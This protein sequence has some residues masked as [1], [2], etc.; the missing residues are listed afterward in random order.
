MGPRVAPGLQIV[1]LGDLPVTEFRSLVFVSA[2]VG[3]H[4][5]LGRA[6]LVQRVQHVRK[7]KVGGGVVDRVAAEDDQ[8]LDFARVHVVYELAKRRDLV[9]RVRLDGFD[10]F[11]RFADVVQRVIHAVGKR[12]N[13]RRLVI[14]RDDNSLALVRLQIGDDGLYPAGLFFVEGRVC[15]A[16]VHTECVRHR[17]R[18]RFN[19]TGPQAEPMVGQTADMGR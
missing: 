3:P 4:L 8:K 15:S 10:V 9:Y 13:D 17:S 11:D 5:D 1:Q 7:M 19:L 16:A 2:Q 14:S 12:M 6:L 18:D